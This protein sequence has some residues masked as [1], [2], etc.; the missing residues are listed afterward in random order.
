MTREELENR[1]IEM[2]WK[3]I[4]LLREDGSEDSLLTVRPEE[5]VIRV[6]ADYIDKE[7]AEL[8]IM[9]READGDVIGCRTT[10]E[11][12]N[13]G[14]YERGN[15]FDGAFWYENLPSHDGFKVLAERTIMFEDDEHLKI[16]D[17]VFDT[18]FK[19]RVIACIESI[20]GNAIRTLEKFNEA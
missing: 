19:N 18:E 13:F 3:R 15:C 20:R 11:M 12:A 16:K 14:R 1:K 7:D 10:L 9:R 6:V 2:Y 5:R 8:A 4:V 17:R